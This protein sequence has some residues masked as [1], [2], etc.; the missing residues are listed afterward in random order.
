MAASPLAGIALAVLHPIAS[1]R[2]MDVEEA[3]RA[4]AAYAAFEE[5]EKGTLEP[6]KLADCVLIDRDIT[7]V[8]AQQLR[9]A[10][11]LA[12]IVGGKVVYERRP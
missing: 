1:G 2:T 3:I 4:Y 12:T 11:V 9:E 7:R 10:N 5:K 8:P 6:G